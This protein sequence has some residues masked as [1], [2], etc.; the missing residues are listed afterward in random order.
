[1]DRQT[2]ICIVGGGPSGLSAAW[3]L[4]HAGF[5]SV[6]VLERAPLPGGKCYTLEVDGRHHEMGAVLIS[7]GYPNTL[8]IVEA[9]GA[10]MEV[11]GATWMVDPENGKI[12]P[13]PTPVSLAADPTALERHAT[14]AAVYLMEL[15]RAK[16]QVGQAGFR[17]ITPELAQPFSDWARAHGLSDLADIF[18]VPLTCFGYGLLSETPT[19]YV[20][21]NMSR[22]SFAS[23]GSGTN[24][25]PRIL[26]RG[27]QDLMC[28]MA[29]RL[30][31]VR[32]GAEVVQVSRGEDGVDV[33][34]HQDGARRHEHFDALIVATPLDNRGGLRWLSL[35][36]E[37]K[38]LFS[39]VNYYDYYTTA[40]RAPGLEPGICYV[41]IL[42]GDKVVD[43]PFEFPCLF[44][45]HYADSD[46]AIFYTFTPEPRSVSEIEAAIGE[47]LRRMGSPMGEVIETRKWEYFPHVG[48]LDMAA[49]WF[50]R[51][52]AL[53]GRERTWYTG[54][55]LD[56]DI[57]EGAVSFSKHVVDTWFV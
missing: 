29:A 26:S 20:M 34:Y 35:S 6:T 28:R 27:Y 56:F 50:D 16:K 42:K 23:M 14:N 15:A 55:Q 2:R 31:D 39:R 51:V 3:Y 22:R 13:M 44:V 30:R 48:S 47:M 24:E 52:E 19:A 10:P 37:E 4:E 32:V 7:P 21:K 45:R 57:V 33:T 54:G 17:N 41:P 18:V 5:T 12:K 40:V 8:K 43:P 38:N 11:R 53:Q 36:E 25:W 49:G 1:M 9:T 46:V